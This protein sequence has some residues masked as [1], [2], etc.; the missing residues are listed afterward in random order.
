MRPQIPGVPGELCVSGDGLARGYLGGPALTAARFMPHPLPQ[1]PGERLYRTGDRARLLDSGDVEFLGRIDNQVKLRGMRI[2]LTEIEAVLSQHP[3]VRRAAA[4]LRGTG[5]G[6]RIV[7]WVEPLREPIAAEELRSFAALSLPA[8][9]A[10]SL[11]VHCD[12]LPL[13]PSGKIDRRAL[14]EAPSESASTQL[15][16]PR[17]ALEER[18]AAIW[19]EVLR[20]PEVGV[21]E[22]FFEI[23]GNSLLAAQIVSRAGKAG[24]VPLPLRSLFEQ[25]SI[26]GQAQLIELLRLAQAARTGASTSETDREEGEL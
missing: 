22:N 24:G 3:G 20:I 2:D 7:A 21:T 23:G 25:P 14:P 1:R 19:R 17:N 4:L 5:P 8:Y 13:T 16:A 26:A 10:P 9:M 11:F 15:V 18:L 6:A 12:R